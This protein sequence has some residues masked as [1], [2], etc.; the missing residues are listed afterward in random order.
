MLCGDAG[1]RTRVRALAALVAALVCI[2]VVPATAG[3]KEFEV[4]GT[5]DDPDA[6]LGIGCAGLPAEECTLRAAIEVSNGTP[7]EDDIIVFDGTVFEGQLVDTIV[8]GS[9]LPPITDKVRIEGRRC[10]TEG[11]FEGPCQGI[12]GPSLAGSALTVENTDQVEIE[13]LAITGA[14]TGINIFESEEVRVNGSWL[15]VKL[16][17][18]SGGNTTGIFIDPK[19]NESRIGG[20]GE[21]AGNVFANN[22][23]DGLDILGP[24]NTLVL[25]NLFGV[26]PDGVTAAANGKDIEVNSQL[27]GG[28]EASGTI[29]GRLREEVPI[30]PVCDNGCNVIAGA[31][32]SGIDLQGDGGQESPA[33]NTRIANNFIGLSSDGATAVPNTFA[34][35]RVGSAAETVVGSTNPDEA[36]R[37]NGGQYGVFSGSLGVPAKGLVV[38]GNSIGRNNADTA[39]LSP[40]GN[41]ISLDSA[42]VTEV[43]DAA[44]ILE[45]TISSGGL[46]I[47]QHGPGALIAGN[48]I[49]GGGT[50]LRAY[51]STEALGNLVVGNLIEGASEDALVIENDLNE[52]LGNEIFGSGGAGVLVKSFGGVLPT[53]ENLIGGDSPDEENV[54][55]ESAGAAIRIVDVEE[56]AN[57]VGRNNGSGN[58]GLFID[59][60]AS[61]PGTEPIGPNGGIEP[62][63]FSTST[64]S[65]ASGSGAEEAAII[66]V[67][68]KAS[69]STG[70][71]ESFLA[72]TQA[73]AEGNWKVTY[74]A[75][76]P[77]GTIV[78]A[79]QTSKGATSELNMATTSAEPGNSTVEVIVPSCASLAQQSCSGSSG[80]TADKTAPQTKIV[81][82]PKAKTHSTTARF[83]FNSN[84][85][86]S[87]FQ[88]KLD[89]KPFKACKSPKKYKKLKPGK[90]VF[91][92]R[93]ID[94][95]GNVDGSPAKR[96]FTVLG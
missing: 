60:V 1:E 52:V 88:C 47:E 84:E 76:I 69:A 12:S 13:G 20:E 83:K 68:R 44:Q 41:A 39:A 21:G 6:S 42:G 81:K 9:G 16:D 96:K 89:K 14:G 22:A 7:A 30:T 55:S 71:L 72:E 82:G 93:A 78:A 58:S 79:T 92:V 18:S 2:L 80:A 87:S 53:T 26:K 15:G 59:L 36:N 56:T 17:G 57:E 34:G 33:V 67:F 5:G 95:A 49:L 25:G 35:V 48:E 61:N 23:G 86:G 24:D 62:P 54:I 4:N 45:N 73:D 50:A 46:T 64:Q 90:H 8:V 37:I 51:G 43:A 19:S 77:A 31:T 32:A 38:Q 10:E 27:A 94:K 65:T 29:I 3:A 70:E 66:R 63:S 28:F 74:P 11:G 91:K 40:P 75:S 85:S